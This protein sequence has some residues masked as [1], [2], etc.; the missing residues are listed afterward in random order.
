[1]TGQAD[2]V[3]I[4]G[5]GVVSPVGS[6][7]SALC[8]SLRASRSGI[9]LWQ[10]ELMSKAFPA[11]VIEEDFSGQ[12]SKLELPYLDRCSQLAMLAANQAIDDAGIEGFANHEQ[13]AGVYYGS[14][15]RLR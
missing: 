10:S 8:E 6:S 1:M 11:G 7:V 14:M 3:L 13:R 12:F 4:T 9:R 2:D 5:I 15:P